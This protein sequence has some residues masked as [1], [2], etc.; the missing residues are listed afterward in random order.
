[1]S[2]LPQQKTINQ[3]VANG[4]TTVYTYSFLILEADA[5]ANDIAVYVT[6]SGQS[7][8]P[9][10]DIQVLN[11]DYTVQNVG[12]VSGGTITF[13]PGAI[14][15]NGSIVTIV[16]AMA[17]TIDTEFSLAQN[18]NGANLDSA[19]ERV[20]LM[21]QQLYTYYS[22]NALSYIINSYLPTVGSNFLP[23]LTNIDNQVWISQGGVIIAALLQNDSMSTLRSQLA[24]QAPGGGDGASLIGFYDTVNDEGTTLDQFLNTFPRPSNGNL[25]IGGDMTTNP[26][27]RGVSFVTPAAN[28]FTAD[29]F[30]WESSGSG[31]GTVTVTRA[32]DS[33]SVSDS[34]V[35]GVNSAKIACTTADTS[36]AATDSYAYQYRMEGYDF[37]FIAQRTFT[38]SFWVKTNLPGTYC[39]AIANQGADQV[40]LKEYVVNASNVWQQI[41]MNIPAS[42]ASG[43]WNYANGVGIYITWCLGTGT[44]FQGTPNQWQ[45]NNVFGSSNQ[46][47]FMSSNTNTWQID[48]VSVE[49]GNLVSP[50]TSRPIQEEI[51]LCERYYQK[52]YNIADAPGVAT[53]VNVCSLILGASISNGV[54]FAQQLFRTRM[55]T[56]PTILTY[57]PATGAS[58]KCIDGN[59]ATDFAVTYTYNGETGFFI[60]LNNGGTL[61]DGHGINWQWTADAE[62]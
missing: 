59:S 7:A 53:Y 21:M 42:P 27:Q 19:F 49:P 15:A 3:Y 29:R 5:S 12:N 61:T 43:T 32:N 1:M 48:R 14:P 30:A 18:F 13:L 28:T 24:S 33:P 39:V 56:T 45:T 57:S 26:W 6:P 23:V 52:S 46:I 47:N 62:L 40:Y 8:N 10:A 2:D 38:L 34:N 54:G 55:R 44:N 11:E 37:T 35:F 17:F 36:L 51:A 20:V 50:W 22:N 9:S 31:G 25:I 16:R 4:I 60:V 41:T 58:P